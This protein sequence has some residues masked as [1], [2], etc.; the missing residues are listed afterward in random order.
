MAGRG[1][2]WETNWST[3]SLPAR[4]SST[5]RG[6]LSRLFQPGRG[7]GGRGMGSR[8]GE[9]VCGGGRG[10]EGVESDGLWIPL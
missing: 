3:F 9:D 10:C 2:V 6:T 8:V 1:K 7:R 4:Y 5:S